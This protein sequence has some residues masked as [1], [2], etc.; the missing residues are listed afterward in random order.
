M[1]FLLVAAAFL[2]LQQAHALV[3]MKNANYTNTW[4][5][6]DV[7]GTGYDLKVIRTYNSRTLFNGMFGFG[8]CSD[9][10]TSME[11][12][13]EGN[14]KVTE[15]GAGAEVTYSPRE[16]VK[17]DIDG[18][19]TQII[20]KM[21]AEKKVGVTEAFLTKLRSDLVEDDSARADYAK[22][23]GISVPVKEGT[24]F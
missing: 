23:Y 20:N 4:I 6:M 24:K 1:R 22:K 7:P 21:K 9:F 11:I 18:T 5:D 3:D 2:S 12:L 19:I 8:W 16:V 14:I 15:C 13:P 17:K 10:E